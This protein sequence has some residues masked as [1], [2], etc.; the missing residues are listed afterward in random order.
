MGHDGGAWSA[1]VCAA[2]SVAK[3][4]N[5]RPSPSSPISMLPKSPPW[6]A[7]KPLTFPSNRVTKLCACSTHNSEFASVPSQLLSIEC[8]QIALIYDFYNIRLKKA[9]QKL[10]CAQSRG[11]H[12]SF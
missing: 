2:F 11:A 6:A 1:F 9:P 7:R 5:S 3:R 4:N 10:R 8:S 12:L